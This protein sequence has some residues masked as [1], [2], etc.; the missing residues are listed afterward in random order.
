[1]TSYLFA[2][3]FVCL[4]CLIGLAGCI[5][6]AIRARN[7]QYWLPSYYRLKKNRRSLPFT[8]E[9]PR[10][11]FIAVCDHFEPEWGNPTKSEA[12]ARVDRWCEEY[13]ARFSKFSDSRG[14]VPQHTFFFPQD[15]YAP[16]YLD[17]LATLCKQGYG[18]VDVH[19]H[20]D[21]DTAEGLRNKMNEFRQTLF[22]RHGLLRKDSVTGE[23]VYGFIHGNWA[24][25]NSRPDGR[26][27]GVDNEI[28]VL[29]E[30]GCYADLTMPSAPSN[31]QTQIINSLYYAKQRPNERKSHDQGTLAKVGQAPEQDSLLM[32]QGP[33]RLDWS[34]RKWGVLPRIE[35][36]DLHAGRPAT[37]KRFQHWLAADVHVKGRPDWTFIKL[38]THGAKTGNIDTLLGSE[39]EAFHTDL[40]QEAAQH[41]EWKYYYV[42]AWEMA[43][44][45]HQ[46]EQGQRI[47]DFE[48]IH[49]NHSS[50]PQLQV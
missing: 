13:P 1:M 18:D 6:L 35:N 24:L 12:L 32:I 42:T 29:L 5:Y 34:Q 7:M 38:H 30:T 36:S 16:E 23:I 44:L 28:E 22:D 8:P 26:W 50:E 19:L 45:I 3:L 20:H 11:I 41:P 48:A 17:R 4:I 15:Q 31:T 46:A 39:T 9:K 10:H 21:H 43:S 33:L 27:C 47:P 25:C 49:S 40:Q 14:Q 37:L 2:S